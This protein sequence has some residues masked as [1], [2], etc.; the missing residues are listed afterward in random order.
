MLNEFHPNDIYTLPPQLEIPL[1]YEYK[2]K[3]IY[4]VYKY[5]CVYESVWVSVYV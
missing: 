1:V 3:Y 4:T 5:L 2:Y